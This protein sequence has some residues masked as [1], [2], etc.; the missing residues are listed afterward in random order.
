MTRPTAR[1]LALLEIL[2]AGGTRTV[3]ELA[4]R[5]GVDERTVRRYAA[6]LVDLDI[7]VQSVRGRYG[8]YRLS[9]GYRLPPLMFTD[10]EALAV[11]LGLLTGRHTAAPAAAESAA[12]KLHRVLPA[13]LADRLDALRDTADLTPA[14]AATPPE[15]GVLLVLA[16]AARDRQ[17][18]EIG[19]TA[20]DGRTGRRTVQPYG[21]VALGGRWY[22]TGPDS[23]SGELRT[24]RLDRIDS[25][26]PLPGRFEVPDGFDPADHVSATLA[27]TP[28]RHRVSLRVRAPV[29][30]IRTRLPAALAVLH[31]GDD[32]WVRVQL[33]AERLD[34]LPA[35]L[36]GLDAPF[37]VDRPAELRRL[38]RD[39]AAR[40]LAAAAD[41]EDPDEPGAPADPG[42]A[43]EAGPTAEP[44]EPAEPRVAAET[45]GAGAAGGGGRGCGTDGADG[46][47]DP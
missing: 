24:F 20:R 4:A 22:L 30:Q 15:T 25:P 33:R 7:P 10:D 2:Q 39:L 14:P 1:V 36:A 23:A 16:A 17:P 31:E 32:G 11:L 44:D 21:I 34:W 26:R 13:Q 35:V 46:D 37:T 3:R 28:W 41:P 40:L 8:G 29:E 18:V 27:R 45:G 19:Y 38:V 43:A 42:L 47:A 5:L 9:P 6:H 12:A